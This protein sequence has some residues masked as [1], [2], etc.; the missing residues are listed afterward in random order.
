MF[1]DYIVTIQMRFGVK[2][3]FMILCMFSLASC[4]TTPEPP[5]PNFTDSSKA[6][7]RV[8]PKYPKEA[9]STGTEG[10]VDLKFDISSEGKPINIQITRSW[11]KGVFDKSATEAIRQWTFPVVDAQGKPVDLTNQTVKLLFKIDYQEIRVW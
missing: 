1:S 6:N 2:N 10:S 3:L 4:A 11:P 9:F 8:A 5:K 7:Y